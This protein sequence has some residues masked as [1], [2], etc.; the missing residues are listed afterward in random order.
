MMRLIQPVAR[1]PDGKSTVADPVALE[2]QGF[3]EV[4]GFCLQ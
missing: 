2:T 3:G 4:Q 1:S